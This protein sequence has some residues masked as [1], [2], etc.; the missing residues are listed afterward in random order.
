MVDELHARC[1]VWGVNHEKH[2]GALEH[3]SGGGALLLVDAGRTAIFDMDE[4]YAKR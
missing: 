4:P 3:A 1:G 2:E